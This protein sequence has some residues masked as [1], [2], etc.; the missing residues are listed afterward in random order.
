VKRNAY[1]NPDLKLTE[2]AHYDPKN[3]T[4]FADDQSPSTVVALAATV[5]DTKN[6]TRQVIQATFHFSPFINRFSCSRAFLNFCYVCPKLSNLKQAE[7]E[8]EDQHFIIRSVCIF[9]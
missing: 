4:S 9:H 8:V 1:S 3:L 5:F 7:R 2:A 6:V